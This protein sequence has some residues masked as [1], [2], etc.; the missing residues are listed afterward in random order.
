MNE[1]DEIKRDAPEFERVVEAYLLRLD[2]ATKTAAHETGE[3]RAARRVLTDFM[4]CYPQHAD[5]LM[6]HAA[7]ASL[8]EVPHA[9]ESSA[10]EE[11]AIIR[12]GMEVAAR[13]LAA[14]NATKKEDAPA[15]A[16]LRKAAEAR[17]LPI[18]SLAAMT[19]LSVPVLMKLDRRLIRYASIP[20]QVIERLSAGVGQTSNV[21]AA[22]LQGNAQFATR[23]HFRADTAPQ[24]SEPQDFFEAIEKD[25]MMNETQKEEWIKLKDGSA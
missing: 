18:G 8:A 2:E 13:I 4:R 25:L 5:A 11:E 23:A 20:R 19:N 15:F 6:S 1:Q 16:S 24:M 7:T 14:R 10:D 9:E 3:A 22:Y 17:G 12:R 21:V